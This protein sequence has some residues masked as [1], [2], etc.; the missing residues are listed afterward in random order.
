VLLERQFKRA[1][2]ILSDKGQVDDAIIMYRRHHKWE[3]SLAVAEQRRHPQLDALRKEYFDHLV[4][5]SQEEI[6]GQLKEKEGDHQTALRLYLQGGFPA[7][8]ATLVLR[9]HMTD[10]RQL[11][12]RVVA[13]LEQARNFEKAGG[14]LRVQSMY[15]ADSCAHRNRKA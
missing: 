7:R 14:M 6:A 5:S 4:S 1:E 2:A 9:Q 8:A 12:D 10:D 13:A 11:C 15:N 3:E